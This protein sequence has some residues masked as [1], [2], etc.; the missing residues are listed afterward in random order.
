M[1]FFD[2]NGSECNKGIEMDFVS[3]KDFWNGLV[4]EVYWGCGEI[5]YCYGFLG[6]KICYDYGEISIERRK[7]IFDDWCLYF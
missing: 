5:F 1:N 2:D 3:R 6:W 7:I 4:C